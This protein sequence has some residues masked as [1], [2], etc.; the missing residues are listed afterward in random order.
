M[1][2]ALAVRNYVLIDHLELR[3]D[4]GF[5]LLSGET[6]AG[7]S[8][9]I[10]ALSAAL[11]GRVALDDIRHGERRAFIEATFSR[12]AGTPWPEALSRLLEEA[13]IV[14]AVDDELTLSRELTARGARCRL[15]GHQ[16]T[17]AQLRQ[18]G[19]ALADVVSQH[20][21]QR[22]LDPGYQLDVL[23]RYGRLGDRRRAVE[24]AHARAAA[25]RL[26]VKRH[27][28]EARERARQ[29]DYWRF[30]LAELEA[31]GLAA[32][33]ELAWL[34]AERLRLVHAQ[35]LRQACLDAY[36]ALYAGDHGPSA[37]DI[38]ARCMQPLNSLSE[39]DDVLGAAGRELGGLQAALRDVATELRRH[40]DKLE[41]DPARL[42]EVEQRVALLMDLTRKY[43]PELEQVIAHRDALARQLEAVAA[44]DAQLAVLELEHQE[45]ERELLAA[46][47][48]LTLARREA[49][50]QLEQA[51]G[52]ELEDLE[53]GRAR[54][55]VSLCPHEAPPRHRATGQED[56]VFEVAL[57]PGEP[58]RPLARTASGG[59]MA[60]VMLALTSVLADL[61]AVGTLVFDEVD[62]G[63][64]GRAA[65]AVAEKLAALA[66]THQVLC[67]T[68][69]PAV[70]AMADQH[71]HLEK[72][73][74]GART[75]VRA[76]VLE[77]DARTR[78]L[79]KLA[80]GQPAPAALRHAEELLAR[81][82]T[83]KAGQ[84]TPRRRGR[85]GL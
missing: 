63:I 12:P 32:P 49:A 70:A 34:E 26:G 51:V 48:Q 64:S 39:V 27:R 84:L 46:C 5:C 4:R 6:G 24:R 50:A 8:I 35:G 69:L 23:D 75:C 71:T 21:H 72:D 41:A 20:E 17:Q 74:T 44:S 58:P 79:A 13:G 83:H 29:E 33:G 62:T 60:R 1:L 10:D 76:A 18:A 22:L 15:D 73:V 2:V 85:R 54:L 53:M 68:H 61:D 3:F 25:A 47:E 59:E 82:S 56:V 9:L 42:A 78:E 31:A 40:L 45:A 66:R 36:Q 80:S 52:R 77:G 30:Q 38:L 57:N 19:A 11:G 67:I 81:A 55:T 65:Q 28:E 7:K 43:G 16:V 37:Y 14:P